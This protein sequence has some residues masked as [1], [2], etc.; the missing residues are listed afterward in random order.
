M[1]IRKGEILI[2]AIMALD[3]AEAEKAV[4]WGK[5]LCNLNDVNEPEVL[6]KLEKLEEN[7]FNGISLSESKEIYDN[8]IF[9]GLNKKVYHETTNQHF[10]VMDL[11]TA[12]KKIYFKVCDF[13]MNIDYDLEYNI[14][15]TGDEKK[16]NEYDEGKFG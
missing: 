8:Y 3:P 12:I 10:K 5:I 13:V 6:N 9:E 2:H 11:R 1:A 14:G 7:C 16:Y 15:L 4:G